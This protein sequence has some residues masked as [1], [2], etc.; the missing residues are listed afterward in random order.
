[1]GPPITPGVTPAQF[2][3]AKKSTACC[4]FV[5]VSV[6]P[7]PIVRFVRLSREVP[8]KSIVEFEV[9]LSVPRVRTIPFSRRVV[10]ATPLTPRSI[11][12]DKVV[13]LPSENVPPPL[14]FK[15]P[16]FVDVSALL[17]FSVRPELMVSAGVASLK[18]IV[19]P[20]KVGVPSCTVILET[21]C[22]PLTVTV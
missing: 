16:V 2:V 11:V 3:V 20:E 22:V 17:K 7:A 6:T 1:M 15:P 13:V 19:P 14:T 5:I 8:A 21:F 4:Q 9:T 12:P 18:L 10:P